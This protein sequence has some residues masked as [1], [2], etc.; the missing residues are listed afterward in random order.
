[1]IF[2]I[3]GFPSS[4]KLFLAPSFPPPSLPPRAV[5]RFC[6]CP[7]HHHLASHR[8]LTPVSHPCTPSPH[9][10]TLSINLFIFRSKSV[11]LKSVTLRC[12]LCTQLNC[13]Q[14][15]QCEDT[16][17]D[18]DSDSE[19]HEIVFSLYRGIKIW[20]DWLCFA[21]PSGILFPCICKIVCTYTVCMRY[22]ISR[23][24]YFFFHMIVSDAPSTRRMLHFSLL[25]ANFS[26]CMCVFFFLYDYRLRSP[27]YSTLIRNARARN[28]LRGS[29]FSFLIKGAFY[30]CRRPP[31]PPQKLRYVIS[32][33][34]KNVIRAKRSAGSFGGG[35]NCSSILDN[36][37][38]H[39]KYCVY[40]AIHLNCSFVL[41][42][43]LKTLGK[44]S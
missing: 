5:S 33:F 24:I 22:S 38:I 29:K 18:S 30:S 12:A 23:I 1:M 10:R 17:L 26:V 15:S 27:I 39:T 28:L 3:Q 31:R 19:F 2:I 9:P 37:L 44:N 14:F 16:L 11:S 8:A 40:R 35:P 25:F 4:F 20:N 21:A 6:F 42:F 32:Y 7:P 36:Y 41:T 43:F 34:T 13:S